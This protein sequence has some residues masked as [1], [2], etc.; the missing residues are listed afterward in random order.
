MALSSPVLSNPADD[1]G[2]S[3]RELYSEENSSKLLGM[4]HRIVSPDLS[5]S[6]IPMISRPSYGF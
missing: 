5:A 6:V 2:L 4:Y 1:P 3:V